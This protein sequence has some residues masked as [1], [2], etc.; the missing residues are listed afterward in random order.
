MNAAPEFELLN[1]RRAGVFRWTAL[2]LVRR[3]GTRHSIPRWPPARPDLLVAKVA[4]GVW[5]ASRCRQFSV[6]RVH[7]DL[8]H[9]LRGA[10]MEH[11]FLSGCFDE[12]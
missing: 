2:C 5:A 12:T 4:P 8:G 6:H 1:A 10:H 3:H 7:P 9:D 11:T